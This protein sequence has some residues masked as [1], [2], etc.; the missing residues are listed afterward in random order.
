[1]WYTLDENGYINNYAILG[2]IPNGIEYHGEL[3]ELFSERPQCFKIVDGELFY[4]NAR[5]LDLSEKAQN[6][7]TISALKQ[8]LN[9]TDYNCEKIVEG[10]FHVICESNQENL[11]TDLINFA[12]SIKPNYELVLSERQSSRDQINECKLNI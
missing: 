5:Y 12:N 11:A 3:P 1:M 10:L 9:N 7:Q 4:D 2:M 6:I 8:Y